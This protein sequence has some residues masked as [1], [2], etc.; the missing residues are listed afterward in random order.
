MRQ[1]L[2]VLESEL[3]EYFS[4]KGFMI[5]TIIIAVLGA[6]LL[7]L[8]RFIDL[9]G[10][11][12]VQVVAHHD[13]QEA[14]KKDKEEREKLYLLDEAHIT[15][16]KVLEAYFPENEWV[17]I[18]DEKALRQ[19]VE[20]Q[21]AEAGFVVKA[22]D[23]YTYYVYNKKMN[24]EIGEN[25]EDAMK[26]FYRRD[27]CQ[28]HELSYEVME[29]VY[30]AE[31]T[32]DEQILNKDT[33]ANYFY[34]YIFVILVYMMIIMYGQMIAVS[35]T[36]EKS[37]RAIEVLVTSTTPNSLLFG[38]VIAG[39]IGGLLQF[40]LV[41]GA[42]LMS[43]RLNRGVWG[44]SL[45]V[46]LQIPPEVLLVFAFFGLGGYLF[47]AFLYGA[48]G[49][50]SSKTEDISKTSGGVMMLITIVY[51]FSL[52]Q[53]EQVDGMII[54]I[55]SFLPVS[56]YSTMFARIAMGTVS[57][58]EIIVSFVILLVSII[59]TGFIGA[60]IYRMGT[61]RYGNPIKFTTALKG[62]RKMED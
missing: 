49:A 61:L 12:G 20:S 43:Y 52:T 18:A 30:E 15:D 56:S 37:N 21:E 8:P 34:C 31:L 4:A 62:I 10:F 36:S 57:T 59:G 46:F 5:W 3:K 25:F 29:Q 48:V 35:I 55:L 14:H 16:M 2:L 60:K 9:S 50:L 19:A 24:D 51:I 28:D 39:A 1:F 13:E 58:W 45:D 22:P 41:I 38:K 7:C 47:Y 6:G 40:G 23:T 44:S 33:R 17:I 54:K 27:Y 11:T 32:V 26:V 53:L 42:I